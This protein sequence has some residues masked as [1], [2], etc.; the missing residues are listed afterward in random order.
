MR[1]QLSHAA[2]LTGRQPP[3]LVQQTPELRRGAHRV[4]VER[5]TLTNL[6][7]L[8]RRKAQEVKGINVAERV[9]A[10]EHFFMALLQ[11]VRSFKA[12]AAGDEL[13][14]P[15]SVVAALAFKYCWGMLDDG[16][17]NERRQEVVSLLIESELIHDTFQALLLSRDSEALLSREYFWSTKCFDIFSLAYAARVE[18]RSPI[19]ALSRESPPCSTPDPQWRPQI[20]QTAPGECN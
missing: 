14:K 17:P 7:Y 3:N 20:R 10:L 11:I 18:P 2:Q 16:T 1:R 13:R 12:S 6:I 8:L 9:A 19:A 15:F 4:V 5:K